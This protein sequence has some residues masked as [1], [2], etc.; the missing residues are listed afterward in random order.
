ME[1][2]IMTQ[3]TQH[4]TPEQT[5]AWLRG[6]L[7]LAWADGHFDP[8]EQELI[9]SLTHE[10]LETEQDVSALEPISP[11]ELAAILGKKNQHS[12]ELLKNRCHG[13]ISGWSLFGG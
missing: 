3:T 8:E 12:R 9:T 13:G 4:Y 1:Q 10:E 11:E 5:T 2:E 7:A 6:L